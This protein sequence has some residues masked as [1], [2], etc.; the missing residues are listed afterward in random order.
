MHVY[1]H[2]FNAWQKPLKGT[3][4]ISK[5]NQET[6]ISEHTQTHFHTHARTRTNTHTHKHT[7]IYK[8]VSGYIYIYLMQNTDIFYVYSFDAY[9]FSISDRTP[10]ASTLLINFCNGLIVG[11][12]SSQLSIWIGGTQFKVYV[13]G[14]DC[15]IVRDANIW[16]RP[17]LGGEQRDPPATWCMWDALQP[18]QLWPAEHDVTGRLKREKK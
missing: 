13:N 5:S 6:W 11:A 17:S 7:Y 10:M 16:N 14:L 2:L 9:N 8:T 15:P 3:K 4:Q 18:T 1:K 12:P